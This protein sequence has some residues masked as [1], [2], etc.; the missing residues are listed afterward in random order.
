MST[1]QTTDHA[2]VQVRHGLL[3]YH[4]R[5]FREPPVPATYVRCEK[6]RRAFVARKD[7]KPHGHKCQPEDTWKELKSTHETPM[8]AYAAGLR[9]LKIEPEQLR[10]TGT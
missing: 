6:C 8:K 10:L 1:W 3:A 9:Y 2:C 5:V 7:G 4:V